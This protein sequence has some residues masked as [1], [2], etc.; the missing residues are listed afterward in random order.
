MTADLFGVWCSRE[1]AELFRFCK[2][3]DFHINY[4]SDIIYKGHVIKAK[5]PGPVHGPSPAGDSARSLSGSR[6]DG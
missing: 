4:Y 1:V 5:C 6:C 3:C 2:E